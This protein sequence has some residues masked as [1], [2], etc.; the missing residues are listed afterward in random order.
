MLLL[1]NR[2]PGVFVIL[3]CRKYGIEAMVKGQVVSFFFWRDRFR[4]LKVSEALRGNAGKR[5]D[6]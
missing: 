5:E 3:R 2:F 1:D 4:S 6:G